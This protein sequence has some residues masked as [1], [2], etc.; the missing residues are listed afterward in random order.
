MTEQLNRRSRRW[1]VKTG[2]ITSAALGFGAVRN[3]GAQNST[4]E[5]E[6]EQGQLQEAYT[7]GETYF[8]GTVFRVIS[9]PLQDTPAVDAPDRLRNYS[10]R[11]IEFFNTNEEGYLLVPQDTQI[12]EGTKYVFD[13]WEAPIQTEVST[14]EFIRVQYRPLTESDLPFDLEVEEDF[15]I[16]DDSGGEAAVRPDNFFSS[17]PFTITSGPQGWVPPDVEQSGLFTDYNTVHAEY[18]GTNNQ[19]LLFV[20][21]A[22]ETEQGQL[23]VM[24][25]ESEIFD[26][27]GNLVAAEFNA[28]DEDTVTIDRDELR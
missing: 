13:Q 8:S 18:F 16:L 27:A 7:T 21:E 22:A 17:A 11:V 19:F 3:A 6:T 14:S 24:R 2:A 1:F 20:Q 23:Y 12:E 9:P 25:D 4:V 15:D 28:I 10:V 5:S 26:P